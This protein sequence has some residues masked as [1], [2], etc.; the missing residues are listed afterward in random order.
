[1]KYKRKDTT[2]ECFHCRLKTET[3]THGGCYNCGKVKHSFDGRRNE[4]R[5]KGEK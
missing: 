1:M 4:A 2:R 5:S 3:G